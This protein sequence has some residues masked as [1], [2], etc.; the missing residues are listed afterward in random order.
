M[1]E[2]VF[3]QIQ[4]KIT[5]N[6][7]RKL[8]QQ[9]WGAT[10]SGQQPVPDPPELPVEESDKALVGFRAWGV[11][12]KAGDYVLK[13]PMQGTQWD[14]PIL[15]ADGKPCPYDPHDN[16]W[17]GR[18]DHCHGIYAHDAPEWG[19]LDKTAMW[20]MT[21]SINFTY[22]FN[23]SHLV[24]ERDPEPKWERTDVRAMGRVE[25]TGRVVVH[26]DGYRAEAARIAHLILTPHGL[27]HDGM[28]E[29]LEAKYHCD[30]SFD[31]TTLEES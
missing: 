8:S 25:L 12:E 15:R 1:G 24:A 16:R 21:A 10:T 22:T 30:V 3:D 31:P 23:G 17:T 27:Y 13:S 14:G 11:Y 28:R 4:A 20:S 29:A 7:A 19:D 9:M 26:E 6:I 18:D 2:D 5:R